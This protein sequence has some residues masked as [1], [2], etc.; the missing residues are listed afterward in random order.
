MALDGYEIGNWVSE[1]RGGR[2]DVEWIVNCGLLRVMD[3]T[4]LDWT[5]MG[6]DGMACDGMRMRSKNRIVHAEQADKHR[7]ACEWEWKRKRTRGQPPCAT[8]FG[9]ENVK[10]TPYLWPTEKRRTVSVLETL[11]F[12][13]IS[14]DTVPTAAGVGVYLCFIPYY[15]RREHVAPRCVAL[16]QGKPCLSICMGVGTCL[17]MYIMSGVHLQA[18][19]SLIA[20]RMYSRNVNMSARA[21]ARPMSYLCIYTYAPSHIV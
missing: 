17:S 11:P 12:R 6:C 14:T 18:R 2:G 8:E 5:A 4:G 20:A 19:S 3:W 10:V 9:T 21:A 7:N 13:P 16:S 1:A 15:G